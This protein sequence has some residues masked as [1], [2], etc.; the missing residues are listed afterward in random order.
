MQSLIL[1]VEHRQC[2]CGASFLAPNPRTLTKREL[3]N[4]KATRASIFL[5]RRNYHYPHIPLREILHTTINID[6]C[7]ECFLTSNGNQFELFPTQSEPELI[8]TAGAVQEKK[9]PPPNPFGLG[10]F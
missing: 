8:F 7:P 4:L 10:Y 5:P 3:V 2:Q 6:S 1:I 9:P